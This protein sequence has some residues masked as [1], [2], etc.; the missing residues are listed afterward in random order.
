MI[1]A[2]E[3]G[4]GKTHSYLVPL[5]DRLCNTHDFGAGEE[6]ILHSKIL[7]VLCP[8]VMLCEQVVRMASDVC[9]ENGKPLLRVA[10]VCGRS[11]SL[12]CHPL[13][14]NLSAHAS[15]ICALDSPRL[16]KDGISCLCWN[17]VSL[18]FSFNRKF[19]CRDGQL[20]SKI[21]LCRHQPHC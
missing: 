14:H 21:L 17:F 18:W 19:N 4:S 9:G 11:V 7:L 10:A 20:T 3:T 16:Q 13:L 6:S 12:I 2:A 8:N 5:I 1:I 15:N